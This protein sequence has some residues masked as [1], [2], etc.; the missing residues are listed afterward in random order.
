[1]EVSMVRLTKHAKL[2]GGKFL[3]ATDNGK[4]EDNVRW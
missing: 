2:L 4:R 3:V 1:M